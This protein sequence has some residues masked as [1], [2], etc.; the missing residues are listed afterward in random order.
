MYRRIAGVA[1]AREN[2]MNGWNEKHVEQAGQHRTL[3]ANE[4][5]AGQRELHACFS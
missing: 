1:R 2:G 5:F 4:T 3:P